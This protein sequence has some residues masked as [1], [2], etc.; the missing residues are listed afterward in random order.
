MSVVL[1][2][3][4]ELSPGELEATFTALANLLDREILFFDFFA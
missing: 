2:P 4:S 1:V 3:S